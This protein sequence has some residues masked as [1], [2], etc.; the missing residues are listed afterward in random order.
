M[1]PMRW[2]WGGERES[3]AMAE[4]S[5]HAIDVATA[6]PAAGMRVSV[7]RLDE[8]GR[9]DI[10]TGARLNSSGVL[11]PPLVDLATGTYEVV[12]EIGAFYREAADGDD[13]V[14]LDDAP[15]RF[16]IAEAEAHYHLPLKFTPWGFSLFRGG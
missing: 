10:V 1:G 2:D 16:C 15:F 13:P 12:F 14:F 11:D 3:E 6:L 8:I 4:I 9:G 7:C 5:I